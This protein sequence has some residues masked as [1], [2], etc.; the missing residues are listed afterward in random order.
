VGYVLS[1]GRG[2]VLV[3]GGFA[4]PAVS[5]G[6]SSGAALV[7]VR[8]DVVP[9]PPR[10]SSPTVAGCLLGGDHTGRD[11]WVES[12]LREGCLRTTTGVCQCWFSGHFRQVF[13]NTNTLPR[14]N[15]GADVW[16]ESSTMT[17]VDDD[18]INAGARL[19][20]KL[21]GVC[22]IVCLVLVCRGRS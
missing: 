11:W 17:G 16:G 3:R 18:D 12:T 5:G 10:S 2:L 4:C 7:D 22:V 13:F 19:L 15:I 1:Q 8:L 14:I 21:D 9:L 20:C 6:L